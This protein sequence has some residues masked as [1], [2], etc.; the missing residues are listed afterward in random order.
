MR[1]RVVRLPKQKRVH[2]FDLPRIAEGKPFAVQEPSASLPADTR[3]KDAPVGGGSMMEKYPQTDVFV[4]I[5]L[6]GGTYVGFLEVMQDV[7]VIRALEGQQR[8]LDWD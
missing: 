2:A 8:L 5:R 4:H 7:T 6:D 3:H 1:A